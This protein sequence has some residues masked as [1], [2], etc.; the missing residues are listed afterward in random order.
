[1]FD[2]KGLPT[3]VTVYEVGPRDGL[4]NE[5]VILPTKVKVD[6]VRRL[7]AAGLPAV[8][9]TSLVRPDLV[10]ALADA[11]ELLAELAPIL[12]SARTAV[13]VP[14]QRGLERALKSGVKEVAV[15]ASA[16]ESFSARN[17]NNSIAGSLAI[18]RPMI[19]QARNAG[20]NVR[21]YISM[22][23]GDPWEGAVSVD[24]VIVVAESLFESGI[25]ELSLGDTIG[26]ATPNNVVDLLD[27]LSARNIPRAMLAVHFHDTYGQA[28]S[29]S[30]TALQEGITTIDASIA[31]L[32]G[33]P[34]AKSAT[35]NLATEDL[36][37]QLHGLGISTGVNLSALV[38]TSRWLASKTGLPLRS[39]T[40]IAMSNDENGAK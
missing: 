23:F 9:I 25:T 2:R 6:L 37:W 16:T 32:G 39:K 3:A 22:C 26:V 12:T 11:D 36:I 24:Q 1:M 31:G 15:F 38:E 4:Q 17:I 7:I 18:Y 30:L 29:N 40:A 34:F 8:E 5:S 20:L 33:C 28:L 13:L 14:N 35:G 27:A 21:G 10:P 19:Q